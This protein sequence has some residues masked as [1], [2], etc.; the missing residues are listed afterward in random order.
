MTPSATPKARGLR[1]S[2]SC[3]LSTGKEVILRISASFGRRRGY[4][5]RLRAIVFSHESG[6]GDISVRG[7][8]SQAEWPEF[9]I[10]FERVLADLSE[11]LGVAFEAEREYQHP[12][13]AYAVEFHPRILPIEPLVI[14]A[15]HDDD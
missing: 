1:E 7:P 6:R 15:K 2:H 10:F 8:I 4:P 13:G 9:L 14:C 12:L 11:R 5:N 3:K